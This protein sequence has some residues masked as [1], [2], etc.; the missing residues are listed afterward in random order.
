MALDILNFDHSAAIPT[1][2][3]PVLS[4]SDIA[5]PASLETQE[6]AETRNS[7]PFKLKGQIGWPSLN[8]A[9]CHEKSARAPSQKGVP[10]PAGTVSAQSSLS[11]PRT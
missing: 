1:L 4:E 3:R 11:L 6:D 7:K 2:F 8:G 9:C 5:F 10:R